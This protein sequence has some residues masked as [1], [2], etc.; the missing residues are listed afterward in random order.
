MATIL[1]KYIT[2]TKRR[3]RGDL[4]YAVCGVQ[5]YPEDDS[6]SARVAQLLEYGEEALWITVTVL[7]HLQRDGGVDLSG[8]IW[9]RLQAL[10]D[11]LHQDREPP[12]FLCVEMH[13][14]AMAIAQAWHHL[15]GGMLDRPGG[16]EFDVRRRAALPYVSMLIEELGVGTVRDMLTEGGYLDRAC[17]G[18][19]KPYDPRWVWTH[20][21]EAVAWQTER[22][23]PTGKGPGDV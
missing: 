2:D 13:P 9:S 3:Y 11:L 8:G 15:N 16:Q 17:R 7:D 19:E 14:D 12:L 5:G 18:D 1:P 21:E 20:R 6:A 10:G 23:R 22:G 4:R